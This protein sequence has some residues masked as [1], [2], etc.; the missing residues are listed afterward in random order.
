MSKNKHTRTHAHLPIVTLTPLAKYSLTTE[1]RT[2]SIYTPAALPPS[3][4]PNVIALALTNTELT[5]DT[6]D[7]TNPDP[8]DPLDDSTNAALSPLTFTNPAPVSAN[9]CTTLPPSTGITL[10]VTDITDTMLNELTSMY[11]DV[12][13]RRTHNSY[14]PA[15]APLAFSVTLIANPDPLAVALVFATAVG[16]VA[17]GAEHEAATNTAPGSPLTS[18]RD[19]PFNVTF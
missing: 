7:T 14:V 19:D 9:D 15:S 1:V 18:G 3:T 2:H 6:A 10:G 8:H 17:F 12:G 13:V 4:T 11:G 16:L 5:L